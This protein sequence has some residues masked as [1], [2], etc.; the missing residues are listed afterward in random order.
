MKTSRLTADESLP[1]LVTPAAPDEDI[2]SLDVSEL[3]RLLRENGALLFRGYGIDSPARFSAFCARISDK[4]LDYTERST[5]RSV[6]EGQVYTSTDYPADQHIPMHCEMAYSRKWP[7][8]VWFYSH[9]A[10]TEG[11]ETPLCDARKVYARVPQSIRERFEK[12]GV[13][14]VRNFRKGIGLPWQEVYGVKTQAELERYCTAHEIDFEW[15]PDGVLQTRAR[16]QATIR[17]PETG[18][19]V[20]FNQAHLFHFTSLPGPTRQALLSAFGEQ[21]MPRN[22]L[23]GDGTP[24]EA[25]TIDEI[26][27]VYRE[28][29]VAFPWERG[30]VAMVENMLVSHGR[31]PFKGERKTLVAMAESYPS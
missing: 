26:H 19:A 23:Y 9:V 20:W 22:A 7:R 30:D 27:R 11:G 10:A 16:A 8:I 28:V 24:I 12:D 31:R 15:K 21:G 13:M 5:P 29:E 2:M 17:H 25:S 3:R 18:E 6:V 1:L 4:L 14:Y